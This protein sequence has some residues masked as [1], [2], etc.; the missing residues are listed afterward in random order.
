MEDEWDVTD[1]F[2][3]AENGFNK[4]LVKFLN[5]GVDP[6]IRDSI[7]F[8][9]LFWAAQYGHEDT[10]QLLLNA[11]A[12]LTIRDNLGYTVIDQA[13]R[14]H[15]NESNNEELILRNQTIKN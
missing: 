15:L 3:A 8:T 5:E 10:V 6:N 4:Q 12:D 13:L 2:E 1:I 9:P 11:G 7:G 14:F